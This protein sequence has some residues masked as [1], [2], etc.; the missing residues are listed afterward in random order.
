MGVD[1]GLDAMN[2]EVIDELAV[3]DV[4]FRGGKEEEGR[5]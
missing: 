2:G 4:M 1:V 5:A 3:G